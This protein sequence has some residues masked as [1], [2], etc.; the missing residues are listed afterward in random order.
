MVTSHFHSKETISVAYVNGEI[1]GGG[2][3]DPLKLC[4]F[5]FNYVTL[6]FS[7]GVN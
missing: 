2:E 5:C 7:L 1:W 6:Q 3:V 4:R